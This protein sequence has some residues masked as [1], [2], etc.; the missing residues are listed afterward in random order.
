MSYAQSFDKAL[1]C[2][3]LGQGLEMGKGVAAAPALVQESLVL[4]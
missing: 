1:A 3:G 4:E 2:Q